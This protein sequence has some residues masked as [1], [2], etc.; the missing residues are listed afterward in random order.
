MFLCDISGYSQQTVPH[1][2]RV[3]SSTFPHC[4]HTV[5]LLLLSLF[6]TIYLLIF[7]APGPLGVFCPTH[8]MWWEAG[9]ISS[10]LEESR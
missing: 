3:S 10:I 5:L 6:S 8:A 7:V 9:V 2:P 1:Y 4:A